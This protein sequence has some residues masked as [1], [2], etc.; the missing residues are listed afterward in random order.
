MH[1]LWLQ[2]HPALSLCML[3]RAVLRNA[4]TLAV[5]LDVAGTVCASASPGAAIPFDWQPLVQRPRH[6]QLALHASLPDGS[7][8]ALRSVPIALEPAEP[9]IVQCFAALPGASAVMLINS[10][11]AVLSDNPAQILLSCLC[12]PHPAAHHLQQLCE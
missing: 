11:A 12:R 9:H 8:L 4:S 2:D 5:S 1:A 3:P 7:E 6:A 10:C